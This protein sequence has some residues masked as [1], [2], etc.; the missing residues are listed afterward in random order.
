MSTFPAVLK[1]IGE[2]GLF[3]KRVVAALCL[4][5]LFV[6]FD[7]ISQ[8]FTGLTFP[9]HC[10]TDWILKQ[11][12]NLTEERQKNLTIPVDRDGNYESC[13]MF[14]P[15][16]WD[17]E[18][19]EKYGLNTTT[20]C[21]NGSEFEKPSG[22]SSL[23]TEFNLVCDQSS[24]IEASQ[25]IYMAGL[26][27]GAL[28]LVPM[29]DRIGR[30]RV[31]LLSLLML[32]LFGV[33]AGFS[34]NFYVYMVLKFLSGISIAGIIANGFVIGGEWTESSKFALCATICHS[35][36]S[37]GLMMLAGI[38]YLIRDWRILHLVLF[39]PLALVLGIFYWV[40]PESARWLLT[41]GRKEEAIRMIRWAAKVNGRAAPDHLL[42]KLEDEGTAKTGTMID[43]LRTPALRKRALIMSYQWF[44]TSLVF[45]GLSLNVGGFGLNIYLTQ[46]IFGLVEFPARF[47]VLPL[48]NYIGR[49]RS[50]AGLLSF[51]G[52]AC[53]VTLAIPKDLPVLVT[54]AAVLGKCTGTGC[55]AVIYIYT[56]ELYPTYVRQSGVSLNSAFARVAGI[57][58]PLVKLLVMY[59]ETIPMLIYGIVPITSG[60]LCLFLPETRNTQLQDHAE[61]P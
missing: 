30:R 41:Q 15:V 45:Y 50:L 7:I 42:E 3:Q 32:F 17:L 34:P 11:A 6:T 52:L 26:L 27:V 14:T 31:V 49:R 44:G 12:P 59:H 35:F 46:F 54:A 24:L 18:W 43:I 51:T 53:L 8:V 60:V 40:L 36:Y 58:A 2:F 5:S 39:S 55:F 56:A 61:P 13:R 9:N 4:P 25:S 47:G 37:L 22:S 20:A 29:A 28:V 33:G 1:E 19:I 38:T 10:N 16:D 21:I 48:M 23:V 57:L